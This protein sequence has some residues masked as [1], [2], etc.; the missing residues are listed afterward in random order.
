[1]VRLDDDVPLSTQRLSFNSV[2]MITKSDEKEEE[3][4][5]RKTNHRWLH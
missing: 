4:E 3:E 5:L 2:T 1:M